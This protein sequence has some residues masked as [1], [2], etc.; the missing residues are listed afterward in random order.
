MIIAGEVR[1]TAQG[2][3]NTGIWIV[4]ITKLPMR[5]FDPCA[6]VLI[7]FSLEEERAHVAV[8]VQ[9]KDFNVDLTP[10]GFEVTGAFI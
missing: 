1:A 8:G 7:N 2:P 3:V 4:I 9:I 10:G 5:C 6:R